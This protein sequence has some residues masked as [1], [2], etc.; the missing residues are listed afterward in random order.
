VI[1]VV[2]YEFSQ[3]FRREP[4]RNAAIHWPSPRLAVTQNCINALY[5]AYT[6][7]IDEK[8]LKMA[9]FLKNGSKNMAETCAIDF[10]YPT[11]YSTSIP[12][13]S[14]IGTP[15]DLSNVNRTALQKITRKTNKVRFLRLCPH[16]KN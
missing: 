6:C 10:L 4:E 14:S 1:V 8:A 2:L 5:C 15:S 16:L 13:G 12:I 3:V 7:I 9:H 11:Y